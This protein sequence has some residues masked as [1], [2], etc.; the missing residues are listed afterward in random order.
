MAAKLGHGGFATT[1]LLFIHPAVM[2][3]LLLLNLWSDCCLLVADQSSSFP[4]DDAGTSNPTKLQRALFISQ[5][6]S[7]HPVPFFQLL[8]RCA[9]LQPLHM[10]RYET[11]HMGQLL[12][13]GSSRIG[14]KGLAELLSSPAATAALASALCSVLKHA[15]YCTLCSSAAD[16]VADGFQTA[17]G[18]SVMLLLLPWLQQLCRALNAA[19][20]HAL[21]EP[22]AAASAV[23]D[24]SSCSGRAEQVRASAV[25][26][27]VLLHQR[28]LALHEAA[29]SMHGLSAARL[30]PAVAAAPFAGQAEAVAAHNLMLGFTKV[31]LE[32][33][34]LRQALQLTGAAAAEARSEGVV[35]PASSAA[36]AAVVD[37][38]CS[39]SSSTSQPVHW[40]HLL[41][42]YQSRKLKRARAAFEENWRP[43]AIQAALEAGNA[44]VA[45]AITA[46]LE[47]A[48]A[49]TGM[50]TPLMARLQQMAQQRM[51]QQ[52]QMAQ[53]Q[54]T[55][56]LQQLYQDSL[57]FCRTLVAVAPLPVVCNNPLCKA[58][59]GVSD[60][61]AA[62]FMCAG[63][64]CRYCSAACQAACWRGHKK[65]CRR[66]VACGMRVE[67]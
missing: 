26:L 38:Q 55:T 35:Q 2:K 28:M 57:G 56:Q 30:S 25:F 9:R 11:M 54:D 20:Q 4:R 27:L 16:D 17:E 60:A 6:A 47:A 12:R 24:S 34:L 1:G 64:G 3:H 8:D 10:T 15:T 5:L 7:K 67:D 61:A 23:T 36:T 21:Q 41:Q 51:A 49:E 37:A 45:G 44:A 29:T 13:N 18:W 62:R 58:L 53:Q 50:I 65:A 19:V 22:S 43:S 33:G 59:H 46:A 66:M 63:C 14:T 39:S 31:V 40:Q 52:Q 32:M 42:L 48:E